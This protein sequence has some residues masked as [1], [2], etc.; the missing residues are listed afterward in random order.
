MEFC[1]LGDLGKYIYKY[2]AAGHLPEGEVKTIAHQLAEGLSYMHEGDFAH[3]DLKP[4]VRFQP[5]L[6]YECTD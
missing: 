5:E 1:E 2:S 6:S 3:R 4:Q